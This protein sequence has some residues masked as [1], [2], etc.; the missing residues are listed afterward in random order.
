VSLF[1][2]KDVIYFKQT[3]TTFIMQRIIYC[4]SL[5]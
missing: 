1:G 4:R 5:C 2:S 3:K